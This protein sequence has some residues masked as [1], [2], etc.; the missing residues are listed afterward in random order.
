[1]EP[2]SPERRLQEAIALQGQGHGARAKQIC[3]DVLSQFPNH[4]VAL[5]VLAIMEAQQGNPVRGLALV[6][7][8]IAQAPANANF[9]NTRGVIL[10]SL[11]RFE[12][13]LASFSQASDLMPGY[14]GAEFNLGVVL[15]S[16]GRYDEAL[17]RY[18]NALLGDARNPQIH[19]NRGNALQ[20][21]RHFEEALAAY[22]QALAIAPDFPVA[23]GNRGGALQALGRT[24]E[25]L[26]HFDRLVALE[27]N[28]A[29]ALYNRANL[30]AEQGQKLEAL[31]NFEKALQIV[32]QFKEALLG[33]A[34]ILQDLNRLDEAMGAYRTLL[35]QPPAREEDQ[36]LNERAA[37][38]LVWCQRRTCSWSGLGEAEATA[39]RA[40]E[41]GKATSS[42]FLALCLL[43]DPEAQ[44]SYTRR[45]WRELGRSAAPLHTP[46]PQK[47]DRIRVGYISGDFGDHAT[48]FLIAG[49]L[50]AHDR[51]R[52]E[53]IGYSYSPDDRSAMRARLAKA[54]ERFVDG[55]TLSDSEF[56]QRIADDGVDI[57]VDLKGYTRGQ[58]S[59]ILAYRPAP[60]CVHYLGYPGST[61]SPVVDYIVADPFLVRP[62][63]ERYFSEAVVRLPDSYQANDDKRS[64]AAT[65]QTRSAAGLP[66]EAFVF[67]AFNRPYKITPQVFDVWM[68]IL[69]AVPNGVLWFVSENE[70]SER[71][72][73]QE[74]Q[75]RGIDPTRLI[76]AP[77]MPAPEHLARHRL[78]DLFLDT[79]PV[80]AHTTAS[81]A[82]WTGL[83]LISL[84]GHSFISRVSGSL[85][86]ALDLPELIAPNIAAYEAMAIELAQKPEALQSLR[87]KLA[88]RRTSAA[89]FDTKRICRNI[90]TAYQ[91]MWEKH[92]KGE[93]PQGFSVGAQS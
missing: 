51:A 16:L 46:A 54:F 21:L 17:H 34:D 37:V 40:L 88:E 42:P 19:N 70:R 38:E 58:R 59:G 83:P 36:A 55:R 48:S 18:D 23:L 8:A 76:F 81:D 10:Q 30:L 68:R 13:A 9:L 87:Q 2:N 79:W 20:A 11:Q 3:E 57:L 91:T 66:D 24:K 63:E 1:M 28:N 35:S 26:E 50:E 32:P 5:H 49:M 71:N 14:P 78:A 90:E 22:D 67:C 29:Q 25:A 69:R 77:Q 82:L 64:V 33:R 60:I 44:L 73:R 12:E 6:N 7:E 4:A 74:A 72:L 27:P 52:F 84:P 75:S 80:C 89:L 45:Y 62:Q 39:R 65:T 15:H 47:H 41:L 86:T 53:V 93:A 43:D 85:L 56:A 31:A 92:R 61:G